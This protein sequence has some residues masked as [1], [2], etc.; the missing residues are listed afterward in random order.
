DRAAVAER[1][2]GVMRS[3][4]RLGWWAERLGLPDTPRSRVLIWCALGDGA[5]A[6]RLKDLFDGSKHGPTDLS[7]DE[8][9]AIAKL[10]G[11]TLDHPDMPAE[12]RAECPALYAEKLQAYFGDA[13]EAEMAAMLS[14][15]TLDLR[16]NV[17]LIDRA[18]AKSSL[19]KD[20]VTTSESTYSPWGLRCDAKA[21]LSKTKAFHKGFVEIQDEGSQM[22]AHACGPQPGLQVL[23]YCAGAGGKTLALAAAM[24]R[25]GRIVAMDNDERRLQKGRERYKKAQ[26]A[27]IIEVRPLSDDKNKKWLR[28]QGEKFDIVLCDVPCTGTGT[29]RRNPDMRW[30]VYGPSLE[31]LV[32]VQ[33]EILDKVAH[34]VKPGGKLVYA[35]CSLLPDENE[36]QVEAFLKRHEGFEIVPVDPKLGHPF[37]R[38]TPLRHGTDGFFTAVL[39]KKSAD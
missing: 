15:A 28:R 33:A 24:N 18:N 4:A 27:D 14:P 11:Q 9:S 20:G 16:V 7:A 35:T 3:H 36:A 26:L 38:L 17:F 1:T 37:M 2:Y 22:I 12:I 29:W 19:E 5:D 6:K 13:F 39:R 31:E 21:F 30:R 32:A 10:S 23:D 25:K 34:A 8:L